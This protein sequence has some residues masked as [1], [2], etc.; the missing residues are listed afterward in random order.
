MLMGKPV[1]VSSCRPLQR[2]VMDNKCGLVFQAGNALDLAYRINLLK[3]STYRQRLGNAGKR[4]VIQKYNWHL[5]SKKL[6]KVYEQ[7]NS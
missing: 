5:T 4:A 7:F 3:D 6:L 2:I 1:V